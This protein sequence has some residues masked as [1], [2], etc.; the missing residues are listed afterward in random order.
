MRKT[1]ACLKLC[2]PER[3]RETKPWRTSLRIA[4]CEFHVP[5][6]EGMFDGADTVSKGLLGMK[7][8]S[9]NIGF[10][11]TG[12]FEGRQEFGDSKFSRR[13]RRR[14]WRNSVLREDRIRGREGFGERRV[15][16][17]AA[18]GFCEGRRLVIPGGNE[19]Q[20]PNFSR[21]GGAL[22]SYI[23]WSLRKIALRV[24]VSLKA[25]RK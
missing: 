9:D 15:V 18:E 24:A 1:S 20:R 4:N 11:N 23:P 22:V 25:I 3:S 17:L 8:G 12:H 10:F 16:E 21:A 2:A 13:R 19:A 14:N 6:E 7:I 5:S